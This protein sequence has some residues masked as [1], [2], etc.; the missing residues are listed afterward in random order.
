[1]TEM[2]QH[3][4]ELSHELLHNIITYVNPTDLPALSSTCRSLNAFLK[5]NAML[6]RDMYYLNWV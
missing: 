5:D 3:F 6:C 1:M 2:A 4:T